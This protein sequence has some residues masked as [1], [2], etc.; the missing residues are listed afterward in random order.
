MAYV[1]SGWGRAALAAPALVVA[2]AAGCAGESGRDSSSE[3]ATE[4]P[5][6][7]PAD[8]GV[9]ADE[10]ASAGGGSSGESALGVDTR[11]VAAAREIVRTGSMQLSVDDAEDGATAVARIAGDAGGFVADEQAR[12]RDHE[13]DITVRVPA[14]GFEDVRGEI[15]GLGD[16]VEQTV[17]AQDVTAEVVDLDSR[18]T[19]LERSV[20]RLRG[21]LSEAGDV[22]Q[23]A[24]VEGE[25]A[26]RETELEALQ[27]QQRVLA[28]QVALGTLDVHLSEDEAI[29]LS[30]D[31]PGFMDG[32]RSGLVAIVYGGRIALTGLGFALP[33][34]VPAA[35]AF[36]MYRWL[37]RRAAPAEQPQE[38]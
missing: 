17:E 26:G 29:T 2:L 24:M 11:A 15:A 6:A 5:G 3:S 20:E 19:S 38:L 16:V 8:S 14:D 9:A 33:F 13:V 28:D 12:V 25:L 7:A 22:G 10:A 23:L 37:R 18:I 32:L 31:T 35:L 27:A 30:E 36:G 21:L 1:R 4:A 34:L